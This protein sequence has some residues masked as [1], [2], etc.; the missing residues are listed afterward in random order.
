MTGPAANFW[1]YKSVL[2]RHASSSPGL[3]WQVAASRAKSA[4]SLASLQPMGLSA[5]E[6]S[7]R[8]LL[9]RM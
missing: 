1:F 8:R 7:P 6:P 2:F 5:S 9:L 4:I 3:G